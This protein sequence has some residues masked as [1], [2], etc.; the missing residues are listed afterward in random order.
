MSGFYIG[1]NAGYAFEHERERNVTTITF[2]NNNYAI[3]GTPGSLPPLSADITPCSGVSGFTSTNPLF[4]NTTP[5]YVIGNNGNPDGPFI[6][7]PFSSPPTTLTMPAGHRDRRN[8]F[9][10]GIQSG[11][12]FQFTPGSGLVIGY[13]SDIQL[14]DFDRGTAIAE[15]LAAAGRLSAQASSDRP[16]SAIPW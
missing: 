16:S 4:P 1:L 11:Y 3:C 2:P 6:G 12:N 7:S 10:A 14:A 8:N 5:F 13:E 9:I 15:S